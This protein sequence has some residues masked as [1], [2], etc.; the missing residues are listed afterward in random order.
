M[1]TDSSID[2]IVTY[3]LD[4]GSL[5][6]CL[7]FFVDHFHCFIRFLAI[8]LLEAWVRSLVWASY[9]FSA[10]G[11]DVRSTP[12]CVLM[13]LKRRVRAALG[14][15]AQLKPINCLYRDSKKEVT[16]PRMNR[17]SQPCKQFFC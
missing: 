17:Y 5:T 16:G 15:V 10:M 13:S 14:R 3:L 8:T 9:Q 11:G 6:V 7:S 1:L 2:I 12:F 4:S